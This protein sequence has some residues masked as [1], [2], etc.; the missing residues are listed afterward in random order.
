MSIR[1]RK[2]LVLA[3]I[4]AILAVAVLLYSANSNTV[5]VAEASEA[6]GKY[7]I[8]VTENGKEYSSTKVNEVT[9]NA[10]D[11]SVD[12]SVSYDGADYKNF[13][14]KY[15]KDGKDLGEERPHN[16]GTYKIIIEIDDYTATYDYKIVP[17]PVTVY[18]AGNYE[19]VYS[20][21][22][23]GRT[24]SATGI[25]SGDNCGVI[26]TYSYIDDQSNRVKLGAG[27]LPVDAHTYSVDYALNNANYTIEN[28]VGE[29][30]FELDITP[31]ELVAKADDVTVSYGEVPEYNITISGFAPNDDEKSIAVMPAV[32]ANYSA[33]GAYLITPTGGEAGNYTFTYK[34]GTLII[35]ALEASG[36]I[37]DTVTELHLTG[38]FAPNTVFSGT[39]IDVDSDEGKEIIED[40]R[41]R[42]VFPSFGKAI[43]AYTITAENGAQRSELVTITMTNVTL[44]AKKSY[45]IISISPSGVVNEITQY[46]YS[47]G[48]LSFNSYG[49]GTFLIVENRADLA[50]WLWIGIGLIALTVLLIIASRVQYIA[51]KR[52]V[53]QA[54]RKKRRGKSGYEW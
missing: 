22:Q 34:S 49:I 1:L 28:Y 50:T 43:S 40:A 53:A 14:V 26:T 6:H 20:R 16:V 32:K 47:D 46:N 48:T 3:I 29:S 52:D 9:Y 37:A 15:Q 31:K 35:N 27:E 17:A 25:Y 41:D 5:R 36:T 54:K 18:V 33:V 42:N 24:V 30:P 19:Y 11:R 45:T 21:S 7:E 23:Y 44:D 4:C 51:S 39:L 38:I 12:V 13:T 8:T 2:S 10:K